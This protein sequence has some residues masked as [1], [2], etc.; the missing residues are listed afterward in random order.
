[1]GAID[2][3][4]SNLSCHSA[5][6][7]CHSAR[8]LFAIRWKLGNVMATVPHLLLWSEVDGGYSFSST[9]VRMGAASDGMAVRGLRNFLFDAARGAVAPGPVRGSVCALRIVIERPGDLRQCGNDAGDWNARDST[10]R[11]PDMAGRDSGDAAAAPG[12]PGTAR[13]VQHR[14]FADA[15]WGQP[16]PCDLLP[17]PNR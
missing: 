9:S 3:C 13:D 14:R 11:G 16:R 4:A 15:L 17:S 2:C 5:A 1:M 7:T 8:P 6:G 12:G 10:S